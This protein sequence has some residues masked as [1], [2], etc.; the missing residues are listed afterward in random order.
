MV[1]VVAMILT[2]CDNPP[3]PTQS[4]KIGVLFVG[5]GEAEE[6][7]VRWLDGYFDHLF[8][9]M[10]PGFFA[11]R[12]GWEG[13]SC[14]THI[15]FASAI[16]AEI[17]NAATYDGV[18]VINEGDPIDAWC[19]AHPE[20]E[21]Y[22]SETGLPIVHG[23]LR[24]SKLF[25][26]DTF[27]ESCFDDGVSDDPVVMFTLLESETEN[28][29]NTHPL[30]F[31]HLGAHVDDPNGAG[32]GV[33]DFIEVASFG[34]MLT[35]CYTFNA[36][37]YKDPYDSQ[38]KEWYYGAK[39]TTNIKDVL[40][41]A[42]LAD[43]ETNN[44]TKI[45]YRHASEAFV[46]NKDER[47]DLAYYPESLE[48]AADEL[49]NEEAVDRIVVIGLSSGYTNLINYGPFW[50][51]SEGNGLS[52]LPGKTYYECIQDVEDGYGPETEAERDQ[53]V[54]DK[55]WDMY[56][57]ITHEVSRIIAGR[58]PVT[59]TLE[60]GSSDFYDQAVLEML[61]YTVDKYSIPDD[62][63]SLKVVLTTHGYAGGYLDGA[64]CDVYFRDAPETTNRVIDTIVDN[65]S[66]NGKF[67]VVPG[68]VE[69]SQP[70]EGSNY[71]PPSPGSPFGE[72]ISAGEQVDMAIKGHYVNGLGQIVD[73]GL[74]DD[75]TND[76]YDYVILI[77]NTFDAESSDTL[78]HAR[79]CVLGN[80][81]VGT[82]EGS[83]NTWVR[84]EVDQNGLEWGDPAAVAPYYPFHDSENFTVRVMDESG[85]CS[86]EADGTTVCKGDSDSPTTVIL[87]GTI[88]SYPDN[89]ARKHLTN[90]AV[91]VI[92]EAIKDPDIGGYNEEPPAI[93]S[94]P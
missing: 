29:Y 64:E 91:E 82:V 19:G 37:D 56:K 81:E 18:Q 9:F 42:V 13:E 21:G 3:P 43:P 22:D 4:E 39:G 63:T 16:E 2:S 50:R 69:Y 17:C 54:T 6:Y 38:V 76:V 86:E 11:G 65:F 32:I 28:P 94:V 51:D 78:G 44:G 79:K 57:T 7:G 58:V 33:A 25:G 47:G 15:H 73:N 30:G 52:V 24:H 72:I 90:A 34:N 71:D 20:Y 55:P 93:T 67:A 10:P 88:L 12:S 83:I 5:A 23:M 85:W 89:D 74:V 62:G 70:G 26:D 84:Q 31:D 75:A 48:T 61:H 68:P 40:D 14:Y 41:A 49:I 77:P 87:S 60:Y 80:H 53:L 1:L 59:Y 92:M 45:V 66:W 36:L 35:S 27:R 8:V 46:E